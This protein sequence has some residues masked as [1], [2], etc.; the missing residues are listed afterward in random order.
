[1]FSVQRAYASLVRRRR[2]QVPTSSLTAADLDVEQERHAP[3]EMLHRLVEREQ[4]GGGVAHLGEGEVGDHAPS[5]RQTSWRS[6]RRAVCGAA[7]STSRRSTPSDS[8]S[9]EVLPRGVPPRCRSPDRVA[10]DLH[11][12]VVAAGRRRRVPGP[13]GCPVVGGEPDH[14]STLAAPG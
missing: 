4:L 1:M 7:D 9:V 3:V 2:S 5:A 12:G 6:T 10:D 11:G 13:D 8:A 14:A